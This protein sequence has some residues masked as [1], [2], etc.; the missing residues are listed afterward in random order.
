M[1]SF[2]TALLGALEEQMGCVVW[3]AGAV[4]VQAMLQN[5]A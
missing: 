5:H 3:Q 4:E 1:K 2:L